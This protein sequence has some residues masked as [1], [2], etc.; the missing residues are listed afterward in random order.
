MTEVIVVI[1]IIRRP[2]FHSAHE[3]LEIFGLP[4]IVLIP[5]IVG[6]RGYSIALKSLE[7]SSDRQFTVHVLSRQFLYTQIAAYMMASFFSRGLL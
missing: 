3:F 6:M 1:G 4:F 7:G 5:W 2:T